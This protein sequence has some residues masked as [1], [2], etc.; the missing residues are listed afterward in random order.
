MR[1]EADANLIFGR[2]GLKPL[3]VERLHVRRMNRPIDRPF[4][5]RDIAEVF[6]RRGGLKAAQE[7]R[8]VGAI[9]VKIGGAW[10]MLRDE[11]YGGALEELIAHQP[12]D[13]RIGQPKRLGDTGDE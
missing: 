11:Q 10:R 5:A 2:E 4:E 8:K 1:H 9:V 7:L 6:Q 13:G 12:M 3:E